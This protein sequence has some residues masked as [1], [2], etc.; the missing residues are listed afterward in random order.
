MR[1]D[2]LRIPREK[3]IDKR[4]KLSEADKA[5]IIEAHKSGA[6]INGLAREY[7]VNKRLIQFLLF[8]ERHKKNLQDRQERGGTMK[9]Y[10]KEK[11]KA[12]M[13]EHRDYKL[14]L[15]TKGIIGEKP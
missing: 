7:K 9:Y 3:G 2:Y 10:E 11:H 1:L 8:P 6:S 13:R 12:N 14:E 5:K 4:I 15:K